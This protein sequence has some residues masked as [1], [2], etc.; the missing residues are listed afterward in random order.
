MTIKRAFPNS[1][2]EPGMT[3]RDWFAGQAIIAL[4]SDA[5]WVTGLD[6]AAKLA[7]TDFKTA[8]AHNGYALA[9]A[10]MKEREK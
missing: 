4:M 8:L 5:K 3:L 1:A 10:M 9:D 2:N 7:K 6:D